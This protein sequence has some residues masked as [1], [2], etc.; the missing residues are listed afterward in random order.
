MRAADWQAAV[1]VEA[2]L[3]EF[4]GNPKQ[5]ETADER[6]NKVKSSHSCIHMLRASRRPITVS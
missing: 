1:A 5:M 4:I 3:L 6:T 2:D